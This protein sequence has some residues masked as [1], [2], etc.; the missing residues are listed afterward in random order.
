MERHKRITIPLVGDQ[1]DHIERF[2][3]EAGMTLSQYSVLCLTIGLKTMRRITEPEHIYTPE[4]MAAIMAAVGMDEKKIEQMVLLKVDEI[5]A[6]G[7]GQGA[8]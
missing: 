3:K 6:K 4:Q 8:V 5:V 1:L 7:D 2:S